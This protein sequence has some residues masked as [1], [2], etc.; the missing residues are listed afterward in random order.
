MTFNDY[1]KDPYLT[2]SRIGV[3]VDFYSTHKATGIDLD[4]TRLPHKE[5]SQSP[6]LFIHN[7]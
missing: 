2:M 1:E 4:S 6:L 3:G 7:S 5:P